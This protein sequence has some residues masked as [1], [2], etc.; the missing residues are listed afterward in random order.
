MLAWAALPAMAGDVVIMP[1][2]CT[3][4]G[5]KP[6]L[7]PSHEVVAHRVIGGRE[8]RKVQTC[9][10]VDPKRCRQWT[11]F[12]F[13][14]DCDGERVAWMQV[15]ANASAHTRRRVTEAGGRLRVADTPLRSKRVD[16]MCARRMGSNMEWWSVDAVCEQASPLNAPT[17]TDMPAGFAPMIGL[18]ASILPDDALRSRAQ[19]L[20][21]AEADDVAPPQKA[22]A[23]KAKSEPAESATSNVSEP[24]ASAPVPAPREAP[25]SIEVPRKAAQATPITAEPAPPVESVPSQTAPTVPVAVI[26]AP[27]ESQQT[28]AQPADDSTVAAAKQHRLVATVVPSDHVAEQQPLANSDAAPK[29][30]G[31]RADTVVAKTSESARAT[32]AGVQVP[33]GVPQTTGSIDDAGNAA[34][35]PDEPSA[36]AGHTLSLAIAAFAVAALAMIA[37]VLNWLLRSPGTAKPSVTETRDRE[38]RAPTFAAAGALVPFAGN[39]GPM[40]QATGEMLPS[41]GVGPVI[42]DRIPVSKP[43]A[44]AVLGMGVANDGNVAALKKIIDGLRMNWHPDLARDD[45]DRRTRELRLK[46]INAAWEIL[47]EKRLGA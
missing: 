36:E 17:S 35:L 9:S 2:S 11:A 45:A 10:P 24:Q 46:Q 33:T 20:A 28:A 14:I 40:V 6:V 37:L 16:D 44:L 32:D 21:L 31:E 47:G 43:E 1:F 42:G 12:K 34:R 15:Y 25:A 38:R 19:R 23:G 18:E 27:V 22:A 4:A 26:N 41:K 5:G 30:G 7:R 39:G 29:A 3:M 8:Q 13:D